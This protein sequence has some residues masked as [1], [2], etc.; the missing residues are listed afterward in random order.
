MKRNFLIFLNTLF[1][2]L[3]ISS[4][5]KRRGC[6]DPNSLNYDPNAVVDNGKC[7]YPECG[8]FTD[9]RDGQT[10]KVVTIGKQ[11]WMAENLN[12]YT[13]TGSVCFAKDPVNCDTFGRMYN[14][15]TAV[16]SVPEGWHLPSK[17]EL[18]TLAA[19]LGGYDSAGKYLKAG[20]STGFNALLGGVHDGK[21]YY[22]GLSVDFWSSSKFSTGGALVWGFSDFSNIKDEMTLSGAMLKWKSYVR[23]IKD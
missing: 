12:Y 20:D 1:L 6:T 16:S 15:W 17:K 3:L 11:C 22:L 23:C 4:S 10:Y 19:Y 13:D 5:C 8:E 7:K 14:Y 21:F 18:D 9:P 2:I